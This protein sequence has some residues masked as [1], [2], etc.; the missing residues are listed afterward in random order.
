[1]RTLLAL[2]ALLAVG[3]CGGNS[4]P[5]TP[6]PGNKPVASI[7]LTPAAPMALV[8]GQQLTMTA[9]PKDAGGN[10][11]SGRQVTWSSSA[12]A[13]AFVS[14][15]GEIT[16]VAPGSTVITARSEGKLAQAN[17]TVADGKYLTPAGGTVTAAGGAVTLVV[18]SQSLTAA[19]AITVAAVGSPPPGTGLVPG[20]AFDL[21]PSGT[22]LTAPA[23]LTLSYQDPAGL[24]EARFRLFR[25]D[26]TMWQAIA[27]TADV[28]HRKVTGAI[29]GFGRYAILEAPV[30]VATITVTPPSTNLAINATV[31]LAAELRGAGNEVLTGRSITWTSS[32]PAVAE[33][34][35]TGL[36]TGKTSGGPVTITASSE[37]MNGTAQITVA[38]PISLAAFAVGFFHTCA[39]TADGAAW[40]WGRNTEC[41]L[42]RGACVNN[43]PTPAAVT[44]S[45]RFNQIA[46]GGYYT[47]GIAKTGQTWCWGAN[48]KGQL[49]DGSVINRAAPVLL[50]GGHLFTTISAGGF[51][52]CGLTAAGQ[53]WCWGGNSSG[54]LGDGTT[55]FR[56]VPV[57]V[58]G[59]HVFTT[60]RA[61]T[62]HNCALDAAG[63][64]WCWGYNED[65]EI[66]DGTMI[67]RPTPLRV[68]GGH[69]FV[70]LE[71]G[72]FHTCGRT[73]GNV[74]LCWGWNDSGQ[75]GD[76]TTTDRLIPTTV[77]G[78]DAFV[79]I[80]AAG[81][82]TCGRLASGLAKCWGENEEGENGTGTMVN[83]STPAAV[84]GARAYTSLTSGS[85]YHFCGIQ[86]SGT[87]YCWGDNSYGQLG[88]GTLIN[89]LVPT[90]FPMPQSS[91]G[92]SGVRAQVS[93]SSSARAAAGQGAG[94]R[95]GSK[96][97]G[98]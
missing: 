78:G 46:P 10:T 40:C 54:E 84:T 97:K 52:S 49:G 30:P 98:H 72:N 47:C 63:A 67:D 22:A 35:S 44:T 1:M 17:L 89:R 59:G 60:I 93:V 19:T 31:Q 55:L 33:V 48:D 50:S 41:Q 57:L 94:S 21:G 34:A 80:H 14:Q 11:L 39:L 9:T 3:A 2:S 65:G 28:G 51:H 79:S 71:V 4:G 12:E 92:L 90:L 85:G 43:L 74:T 53:A 25:W 32:N 61:G 69:Q 26:G 62:D 86:S 18:P 37:G 75:I 36:V 76:G 27:S 83:S 42:G 73:S 88:D 56:T 77:S 96:R 70:E 58:Q 8:S 82:S 45:L 38:T 20:T 29:T 66:G 6:P 91:S 24:V 15:T 7:A 68:I 23:T 16:A 81:W 87:V 13:Y 95:T 5:T 64:A